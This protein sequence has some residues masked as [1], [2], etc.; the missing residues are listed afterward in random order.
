MSFPLCATGADDHVRLLQ[1]LHSTT[2]RSLFRYRNMA[3]ST[4]KKRENHSA[5]R[6]NPEAKRPRTERDVDISEQTTDTSDNSETAASMA[7]A[8]HMVVASDDRVS[9]TTPA[10]PSPSTVE[11][12][13]T[14][15]LVGTRSF[16]DQRL[17]DRL[18]TMNAYCNPASCCYSIQ[19]LPIEDTV[20]GNIGYGPDDNTE[21]IFNNFVELK[22][23]NPTRRAGVKFRPLLE[24]DFDKAVLLS[25]GRSHPAKGDAD[26]PHA[27]WASRWIND[28][29]QPDDDLKLFKRS[30]DATETFQSKLSMDKYP[31]DQIKPGNVALVETAV[32]HW[33][34]KDDA[35]VADSPSSPSKGKK[36]KRKEWKNWNVHFRIDAISIIH[37]GEGLNEGGAGEDVKF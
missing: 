26:V 35:A 15:I 28:Y 7:D 2:L 25:H 34:V 23:R 9:G 14:T 22:T 1:I 31:A 21:V 33:A 12:V 17:V 11:G 32:T 30:F 36:S 27:L 16:F 8:D 19:T 24:C 37:Q 5:T 6:T 20:W 13:N 4:S 29:G 10:V 18:N 3:P